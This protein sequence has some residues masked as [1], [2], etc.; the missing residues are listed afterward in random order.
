MKLLI[1]CYNKLNIISKMETSV[2]FIPKSAQIQFKLN[3]T[4]PVSKS[5]SFGDIKDAVMALI[6]ET[7]EKL[8]SHIVSAAKLELVELHHA[9]LNDFAWNLQIIAAVFHTGETTLT[10]DNIVTHLLA[11]HHTVLLKPCNCT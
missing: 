8:K 5:E 3:V 4:T 2:D 11:K 10:V 1:K 7:Q 9:I 6:S